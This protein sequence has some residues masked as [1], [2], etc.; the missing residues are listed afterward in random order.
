VKKSLGAETWT[1]EYD[2]RGHLT[3]LD[4]RSTDGGALVSQVDFSY[5]AL[6]NLIRRVMRDGSLSV[7][8][9]VQYVADGWNP[10]KAGGVGTEGTDSLLDL[11]GPNAATVRRVFG[12]R[13]DEIVARVAAG[14]VEGRPRRSPR[15]WRWRG[16]PSGGATCGRFRG[17]GRAGRRT[18]LSSAAAAGRPP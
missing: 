7:T 17:A 8:S 15:R 6:D 13:V 11:D 14:G 3:R 4:Q 12:D 18:R 16:C 2:H 10:A 9:D 1:Y 5:D